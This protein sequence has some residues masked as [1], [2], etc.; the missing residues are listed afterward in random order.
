MFATTLK[1]TSGISGGVGSSGFKF[2]T[3]VGGGG[4]GDNNA[5]PTPVVDDDLYS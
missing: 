4:S 5:V 3:S 2:P 1:N